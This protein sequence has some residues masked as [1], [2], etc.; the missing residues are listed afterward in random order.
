M[1]F[2][3]RLKSSLEA[4]GL[5]TRPSEFSR[6][7]NARADGASVTVYAARKWLNGEAIPTHEKLVILAVW[8]GINAA[9]LR[10]GDADNVMAAD[11]VIPEANISTPTLALVN[12]IMSLPPPMQKTIREI[13]DAFMRN[14]GHRNA[15]DIGPGGARANDP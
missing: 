8:L 3:N 7:F 10:F 14:F 2:A 5:S 4:A 6:A 12:D 13:V 15:G 9:W 1:H 11:E